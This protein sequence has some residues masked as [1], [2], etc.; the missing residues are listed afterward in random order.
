MDKLP[1]VSIIIPAYNSEKYLSATIQSALDQTWPLVEIIVIDDGSTDQSLVIAKAFESEKVKVFH[2]DNKG[3]SAAR[4]FGLSIA[5]G[6]YIQFLDSDDLLSSDKI[7][8]QVKAL[9]NNVNR[10]AVCSTTYFFDD[11]SRF[12]LKPPANEEKFIYT[13]DDPVNF[14]IRL[15]GGYDFNASMIQPNAWLTPRNLIEITG[16]W[17]TKLTLDDD[18]EFFARIILAS[19]GII[20]TGGTNYYRKYRSLFNNLSAQIN[21]NELESSFLSSILKK[22]YLFEKCQNLF[23][24]RAIFRLLTEL[25]VICYLNEP[26]IYNKITKELKQLPR[27][28]Y[29]IVIGGPKISF[30]AKLIG[31]KLAK[32]FKRMIYNYLPKKL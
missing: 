31:W 14:L 29:N 32:K 9:T 18:G 23:A 11:D 19:K 12:N 21:N 15:W 2:Q 7:E 3:A 30:L 13:T 8:N 6:D 16:G 25:S 4:N 5:K 20:K 10:V 28:R 24:K 26:A 17:N 22:K 27:Y 1:F